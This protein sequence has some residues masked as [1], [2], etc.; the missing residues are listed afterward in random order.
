MYKKQSGKGLAF[1]AQPGRDMTA[2]RGIMDQDSR[3][4]RRME[5][6]R[7]IREENHMNRR[8]VRAREDILYGF[9]RGHRE[10]EGYG[11]YGDYDEYDSPLS[12]AE[13]PGAGGE[14][15]VTSLG[16][17]FF[18]AAVLFGIYFFCKTQDASVAGMTAE[19]IETAVEGQ[20]EKIVDIISHL[21]FVKD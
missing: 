11:G 3:T 2:M 19:R 1:L 17:R 8:Q 21:P 10:Y 20:E 9:G 5:L 6:T 16:L 15:G 13:Y 12:A 4:R 14:G 7:L 18:L